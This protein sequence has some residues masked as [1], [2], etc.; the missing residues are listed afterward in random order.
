LQ[1][2]GERR[3]ESVVRRALGT[4]ASSSSAA[5]CDA[6]GRRRSGAQRKFWQ[7]ATLDQAS[8]CEQLGFFAR[9]SKCGPCIPALWGFTRL[10][11]SG[12]KKP[13]SPSGAFRPIASTTLL[14][15]FA[16][17]MLIRHS[18]ILFPLYAAHRWTQQAPGYFPLLFRILQICGGTKLSAPSTDSGIAETQTPVCAR[19]GFSYEDA[20][21]KFT[22]FADRCIIKDKRAVGKIMNELSL[23]KGTRVLPDD[24]YRC[25]RCLREKPNRKQEEKDWEF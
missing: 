8:P 9:C 1:R 3:A 25:P 13:R 11:H 24:H 17:S 16:R 12:Q 6:S 21:G 5:T 7:R 10:W 18:F 20:S 14:R 4:G 23:P 22:L 15:A 2:G 19:G